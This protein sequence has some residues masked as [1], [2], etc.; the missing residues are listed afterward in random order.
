VL[1]NAGAALL[2]AARVETIEAGIE[3]AALTID[4]GLGAELL[5]RLRAEKRAADDA[6]DASAAATI[7][8]AAPVART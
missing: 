1:L 4:A 7:A 8:A 2:A 5:A 6:R 3:L